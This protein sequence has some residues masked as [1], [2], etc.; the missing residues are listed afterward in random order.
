[1]SYVKTLHRL[2][3]SKLNLLIIKGSTPFAQTFRKISKKRNS[4]LVWVKKPIVGQMAAVLLARLTGK[5]FIWIQYFSNPPTPNFLARILLSQADR[6]IVSSKKDVVR[7]KN[8]GV[9]KTKIRY[10][11]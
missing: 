2:L 9:A 7:L 8:F 10:Q 1:M 3:T 11:K 4:D 5:K 6:I